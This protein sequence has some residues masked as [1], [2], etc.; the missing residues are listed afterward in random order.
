MPTVMRTLD[1]AE[2]VL[3]KGC[4]RSAESTSLAEQRLSALRRGVQ[5]FDHQLRAT[6][7]RMRS[8]LENPSVPRAIRQATLEGLAAGTNAGTDL[9]LTQRVEPFLEDVESL[10]RF[11]K[12]RQ[13]RYRYEGDNIVFA[14]QGDVQAYNRMIGQIGDRKRQMLAERDARRKR[15]QERQRQWR[16]WLR[17]PLAIRAPSAETGRH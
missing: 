1:N 12:S 16:E 5:E 3:Q 9:S 14:G 13:G 2:P 7:E 17:D 4:F 10:I 8:E 11:M 15:A 6:I